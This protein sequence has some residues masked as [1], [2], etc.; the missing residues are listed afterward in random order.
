M[1]TGLLTL[2]VVALAVLGMG[3]GRSRAVASVGGDI[4]KLHSLPF[5]YGRFIALLAA[6]PAFLV[7]IIWLLVQPLIVE[8]QAAAV[9]SPADIP[10][11]SSTALVMTD[12]R[13]IAE[14][15]DR[16]EGAGADVT[17]LK[18]DAA[19]LKT[20]MNNAGVALQSDPAPSVIAAAETLRAAQARSR[21]YMSIAAGI[22][23]L[24]GFAWGIS[25]IKP[26]FRARNATETFTMWLLIGCSLIAVLTTIGIVACPPQVTMFTFISRLP[27]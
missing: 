5:F 3:L 26:D 14:G 8:N 1:S 24:G 20:A 9:L 6:V 17:P 13:R 25:R 2:L 27:T 12:V 21:L 23:A 19:A 15:L 11:G 7:I 4:R 10:D 18:S 22:V 16:L